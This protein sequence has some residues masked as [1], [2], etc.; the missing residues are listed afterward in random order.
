MRQDSSAKTALKWSIKGRKLTLKGSHG[1]LWRA[2][3][4]QQLRSHFY[5][6]KIDRFSASKLDRKNGIVDEIV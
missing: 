3:K 2:K 5:L 6:L 1:V 4:D